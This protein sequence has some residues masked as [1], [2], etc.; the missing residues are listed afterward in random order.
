MSTLTELIRRGKQKPIR[1][2]YIKRRDTDGDYEADWVRVDNWKQ[3]DRVA[4]WGKVSI[5]VDEEDGVIGSFNISNL[6]MTVKNEDGLFNVETDA[7]SIWYNYLNRSL[8]KLKI[9]CGYT[10][11]DDSEV[12]VV[13]VF[14][15]VID[16]VKIGDNQQAKIKVLSYQTVLKKYDISDLSLTGAKTVDTL[17]DEIMN[18]TK[19]TNFIPFVASTANENSTITSIA[20]GALQNSYW[21][22]LKD[23]AKF[24][25]SVPFMNITAF[26]FKARTPGATSVFDFRGHGSRLYDDIF[27]ISSFDDEGKKKVR[28]HW[29]AKGTNFEAISTVPL[30]LKKY[31]GEPELLTID[32]VDD[33]DKQALV[34]SL[35]AEWEYPKPVISFETRFLVNTLEP[36]NKITIDIKGQTVPIDTFVWDAW[37]WDDGSKWGKKKGAII[38]SNSR[39]WKVLKVEKDLDGW[40]TKVKA[41]EILA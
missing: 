9:E 3:I 27:K 38:I 18:Q 30:L 13:S 4:K 20:V 31:L 25:N 24:S 19:I 41:E 28:V 22:V 36:L 21:G 35:L 23:M 34:D 14:E 37:N 39:N 16:D 17:V 5:E 26:A 15:G 10:D 6:S 32:D 7:R 40:K 12:G 8:T 2:C 11:D 29:I 1:K 33:T